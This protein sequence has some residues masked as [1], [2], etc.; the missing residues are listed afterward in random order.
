MFMGATVFEIAEGSSQTPTHPPPP[1]LVKGEGTKRLGKGIQKKVKKK[2]KKNS[3]HCK[4]VI[5]KLITPK[6]AMRNEKR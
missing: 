2:F 6:F 4:I 3:N 5:F 1:T